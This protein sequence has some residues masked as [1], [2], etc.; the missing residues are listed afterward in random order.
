MTGCKFP[1][2]QNAVWQLCEAGRCLSSFLPR[3]GFL[4]SLCSTVLWVVGPLGLVTC[5]MGKAQKDWNGVGA[6]RSS[7][8]LKPNLTTSV[9]W[10]GHQTPCASKSQNCLVCKGTKA[11]VLQ[12]SCPSSRRT[13]V[14]YWKVKRSEIGL[15]QADSVTGW[16]L[17]VQESR[18]EF[19]LPRTGKVTETTTGLCKRD[20]LPA[21]KSPVSQAW[22]Q[23]VK[24]YPS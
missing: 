8:G 1:E 6:H 24:S 21:C 17:A 3:V 20:P 2:S 11:R 16:K 13:R 18:P 9:V 22:R 15:R 4:G 5:L 19:L 7:Q 12:M 10:P 14:S 23:E